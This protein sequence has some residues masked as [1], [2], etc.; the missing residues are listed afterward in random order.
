MVILGNF[1]TEEV[2]EM[3]RKIQAGALIEVAVPEAF[4][5]AGQALRATP[6][7]PRPPKALNRA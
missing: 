1:T 6:T 4:A 7:F 2:S 5:E 3:V